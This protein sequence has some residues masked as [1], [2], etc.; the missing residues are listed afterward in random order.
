MAV[1]SERKQAL[2]KEFGQNEKDCGS[3]TAQ[4]AILTE[5]INDITEH[6][7]KNSKDFATRRGLLKM[8]GRRRR[9][10]NYVKVHH[11]PEEY[12]SLLTKLN[13]RK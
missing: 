1:T 10:L 5:R 12:K 8:V 3:A 9:L 7:K 6:L 13:L 2:C 4:I 11:T